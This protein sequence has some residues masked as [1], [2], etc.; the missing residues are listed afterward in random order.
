MWLMDGGGRREEDIGRIVGMQ[1]LLHLPIEVRGTS[2]LFVIY[3]MLISNITHPIVK[4][5]S[6]SRMHFCLAV[7][8]ACLSHAC[9]SHACPSQPYLGIHHS[10][11]LIPR[12]LSPKHRSSYR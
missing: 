10:F 3:I 5:L 6:C 9:L 12:A 8:H 1:R 11:D 4:G 7:S 2:E